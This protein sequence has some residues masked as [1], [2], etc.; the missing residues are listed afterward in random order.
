MFCGLGEFGEPYCDC[1]ADG[2]GFSYI[3]CVEFSRRVNRSLTSM[4]VQSMQFAYTSLSTH[5]SFMEKKWCGD[6]DCSA[7]PPKPTSVVHQETLLSLWS[8]GT[9]LS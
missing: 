4:E 8:S 5:L 2:Y 3:A 1:L 7:R 9:T 6:V